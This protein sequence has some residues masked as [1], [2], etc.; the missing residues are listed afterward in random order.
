[1]A[2]YQQLNYCKSCKKNVSLNDKG[3]CNQCKSTQIKKTWSVRFR[4]I[5]TKG[6][7]IQKRL[8]GFETKKAAQAGYI[9]YVNNFQQK[10]IKKED[11]I[12]FAT[13][14]QEF[15]SLFL[16]ITIEQNIRLTN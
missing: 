8:T 10:D 2:S 5:E 14:F 3:Q 6:T 11:G 1:M 7:E 9:E 13:L 4:I 16:L 15:I 12:V